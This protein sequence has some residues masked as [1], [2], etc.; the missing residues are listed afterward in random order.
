MMCFMKKNAEKYCLTKST[1]SRNI[2][3][4]FLVFGIQVVMLTC[5]FSNLYKDENGDGEADSSKFYLNF[6][7][8][9]V[10]FPCAVAL[11]LYLYP[12]VMNGM[13]IMKFTNNQ[14]DLFLP[15]TSELAFIIGFLQCLVA[16]YCEFINLELLIFQ[17]KVDHAIIHFVALEV[18]M[19][20]PKMYFE[21]LLD[22]P[23]SEIMHHPPK[24]IH[25]GKDI[26]FS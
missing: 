23:L 9:V 17:S 24:R 8:L 20:L 2:F 26:I 19:E 6:E 21:S 10:K 3:N 7:V 14:S 12:E 15:N 18:I 5:T 13:N 25:K 11:H 16:L 22:N 4:T 1:N